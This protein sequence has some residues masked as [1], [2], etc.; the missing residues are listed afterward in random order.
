VWLFEDPV[1]LPGDTWL[2]QSRI[3]NVVTSTERVYYVISS[4]TSA[5]VLGQTVDIVIGSQPT[6]GVCV[7]LDR[8]RLAER[9]SST[10]L[11]NLSRHIEALTVGAY[12]GEGFIAWCHTS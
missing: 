3:P 10:E 1:A 8:R 4:E 5:E 6:V 9:L 2:A 11:A 12:D 7:A